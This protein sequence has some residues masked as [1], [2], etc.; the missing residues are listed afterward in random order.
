MRETTRLS[1]ELFGKSPLLAE[2]VKANELRIVGAHYNIET[3]AVELL[4]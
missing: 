1:A 4:T 3:G 2:R